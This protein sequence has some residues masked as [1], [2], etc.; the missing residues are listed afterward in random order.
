MAAIP[1]AAVGKGL[2]SG[3]FGLRS[4]RERENSAQ[5]QG[6]GV[7]PPGKLNPAPSKHLGGANPECQE[8]ILTLGGLLKAFPV[9][10][11]TIPAPLQPPWEQGS[12][13]DPHVP[14]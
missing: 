13:I 1:K 7:T 6:I 4:S 2:S 11:I 3:I 8:R 10:V 9:S 12:E 5:G 14:P